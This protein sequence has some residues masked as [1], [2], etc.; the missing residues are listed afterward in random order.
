MWFRSPGYGLDGL[1]VVRVRVRVRVRFKVRIRV[2]IST[3]YM[4]E[5]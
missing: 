2:S 1:V 3:P 4:V 5:V